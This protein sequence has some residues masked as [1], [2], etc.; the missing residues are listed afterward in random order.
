MTGGSGL[1]VKK[2]ISAWNKPLNA[3]FKDLFK[4]LS[5]AIVHGVTLNWVDAAK[6][7]ANAVS[8]V[9]FEKDAGQVAWLLIHRSIIQAIYSL[10]R[11]N[12]DL[13]KSSPAGF[14]NLREQPELSEQDF[15]V[16]SQKLDL[17]LEENELAI[18]SSFFERPGELPVV[19]AM[20]VPFFQWLKG[21]GLTD[22]QAK[23]IS[24]RLPTYFIYALTDQ[25]RTHR[26]TYAPVK[27]ALDTPFTRAGERE[28][29]WSRYAAW[30]Q[31]QVEEPMFY[32]AFSLKQ[33]YTPLRAYYE[34]K[35]KGDKEPERRIGEDHKPEKIV[36]D[37]EKEL[38]AWLNDSDIQD[39]IRIIS[40]GPGFGKSSFAKMFAARHAYDTARR[41]LFVFLSLAMI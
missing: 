3:S 33:V 5:K 14:W 41:V 20:T 15:E 24:D 38:E 28:Q 9:G 25:W 10:V 22:A 17:S 30:L 4:S 39:A 37:L 1:Q 16:I 2:P 26:D 34:R 40:G 8:A 32:E 23:A 29:A 12:L 6:N 19:R 13:I 18:D 31:K 36:V 11:D 27:E 7:S 21:A 35:A